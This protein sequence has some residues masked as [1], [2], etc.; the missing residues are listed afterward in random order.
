MVKLI[1][2]H[3]DLAVDIAP[4]TVIETTLSLI[5]SSEELKKPILEL[6]SY[7]PYRFLRPFFLQSLRGLVD[8]RVNSTIRQLAEQS[9]DSSNPCLYRFVETPALSIE[10]H[11]DWLEYLQQHLTIL[12]DFCLWHLVNY[13]QKHNPNIPNLAAKLFA[14]VQ[15]DL[16]LA[17]EFW[18]LVILRKG[19]VQCIYSGEP[20]HRGAYSIDHFLPW[21]FVAHD[22]L[23]N[24]APT[25]PAVNSSKSDSLPDLCYFERFAQLQHQAVQIVA[26]TP[27]CERLLEDYVLLFRI[28]EMSELREMSFTVFQEKLREAIFPQVQI[29]ANMGFRTGWKYS[30]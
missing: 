30:S 27:R 8:W 28:G 17:R 3:T 25:T 12:N 13:L 6:A 5:L 10:I 21:R 29:A 16:R 2:D 4:K 11:P 1:G 26:H 15:R 20:L 9:F 19:Q 18:N 7:V 14:P 24:L 22:S 23:W